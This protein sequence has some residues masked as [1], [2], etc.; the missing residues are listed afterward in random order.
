MT[1]AQDALAAQ[2]RTAKTKAERRGAVRSALENP[3]SPEARVILNA[4]MRAFLRTQV[5][6]SRAAGEGANSAGG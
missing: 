6:E 2:L 3:G 4:Q 5:T 1:I